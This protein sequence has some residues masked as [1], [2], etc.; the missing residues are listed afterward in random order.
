MHAEDGE[1]CE[2]GGCCEVVE[3]G[4]DLGGAAHSGA[5]SAVAAAHQMAEFAFD[6]GAGGAVV[7]AP[8]RVLLS[9]TVASKRGFVNPDSDLAPGG[10]LGA[11]AAQRT[12]G[13]GVTEV[14][15]PVT[16]DTAADWASPRRADGWL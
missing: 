9:L 4:I 16:V 10:G 13:A 2:V 15:D 6:F 12:G 1:A 5:P 7:V 14:G 3:V 8:G 11:F